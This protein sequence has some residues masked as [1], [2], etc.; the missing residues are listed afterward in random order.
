MKQSKK[1]KLVE[2]II[3]M[4]C[5]IF[6]KVW[7]NIE[8]LDLAYGSNKQWIWFKGHMD[9]CM[10]RANQHRDELLN[11]PGIILRKLYKS[12]QKLLCDRSFY[13]GTFKFDK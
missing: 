11:N 10:V 5:E 7:K 13:N 8:E 6:D 3:D 9:Y 1:I 2:D 4:E 12:T